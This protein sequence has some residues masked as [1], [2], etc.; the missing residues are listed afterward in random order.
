MSGSPG[1]GQCGI[2]IG[3][4]QEAVAYLK[5]EPICAATIRAGISTLAVHQDR[6]RRQHGRA[7]TPDTAIEFACRAIELTFS[8]IGWM[9]W[10]GARATLDGGMER[11]FGVQREMA[12][13]DFDRAPKKSGGGCCVA[14]RG[15][16]Q[17]PG[18]RGDFGAQTLRIV[19]DGAG[20]HRWGAA[21]ARKA[22]P[23]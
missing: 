17:D 18:F 22:C 12:L 7:S 9:P 1:P 20:S 21:D 15:F 3:Q 4:V 11:R 16:E 6:A 10:I 5:A 2:A 19:D 8:S 23:L 14:S 13:A